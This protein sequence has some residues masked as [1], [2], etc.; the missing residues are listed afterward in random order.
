MID[1]PLRFCVA[2]IE[3]LIRRPFKLETT[4]WL[5][6]STP[7]MARETAKVGR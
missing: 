3:K 4:S 6:T 7:G 1:E 2:L 5:G